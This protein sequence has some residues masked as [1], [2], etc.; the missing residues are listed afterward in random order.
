[1]NLNALKI[2]SAGMLATVQDLGRYGFCDRGVPVSGA[3]D[4]FALKAGNLIVGN[5]AGAAA[6]EATFDGFEAEFLGPRNFAV[7][8]ADLD[9]ALNGRPVLNWRSYPAKPGD[10]LTLSRTR[11][12]C[13]AYICVEGGIDVPLVMGS[14]STYLRGQFGGFQGRMLQKDDVIQCGVETGKPAG[15][16]PSGL[17]PRYGDAPF[18]RVVAGPQDD[19]FTPEGLDAFFSGTY[20]LT[21]RWDRMG[22]A[23]AGPAIAHAKGANIISDGIMAGSVQVP[24]NSQPMLLLADSQTVGGYP[25]IA[26]VASFDL[27]LVAQLTPGCRVR[28]QAIPF[29]QAL[30]IHLKKEYMLRS[31]YEKTRNPSVHPPTH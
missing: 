29:T 26:T 13:R 24:G 6:I 10:V 25:K 11:L 18:L 7:T 21:D 14:R 15:E 20:T 31:W 8:G 16:L 22:C 5:P 17:I 30:E 27:P 23:L 4:R 1:M 19:Y 3:M 2:I 9:A 12:G 28:F